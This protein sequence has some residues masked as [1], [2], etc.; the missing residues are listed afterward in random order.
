MVELGAQGKSPNST[1]VRLRSFKTAARVV[2][3]KS[4][5]RLCQPTTFPQRILHIALDRIPQ[6]ATYDGAQA[7]E[8]NPPTATC[9]L[10]PVLTTE[11]SCRLTRR[12]E[13]HHKGDHSVA[14]GRQTLL[15][16]VKAD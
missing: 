12:V 5:V 1:R 3:V 9:K 16:C 11:Q 2:E 14:S 15:P 4:E 10:A 7:P 8:T 13:K 6:L